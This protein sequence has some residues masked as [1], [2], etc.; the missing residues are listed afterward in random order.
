MASTILLLILCRSLSF[1]RLHSSSRFFRCSR[2]A[3][4]VHH[5]SRSE[6]TSSMSVDNR[7]RNSRSG[8]E[9]EMGW[10][11]FAHVFERVL[12]YSSWAD[13]TRKSMSF[14]WYP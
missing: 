13:A 2:L 11:A 1:F 10:V 14:L 3:G 12:V 5:F 9:A 4:E 7:R 8:S 6:S